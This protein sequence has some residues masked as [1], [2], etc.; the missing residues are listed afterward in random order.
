MAFW[1]AI[2]AVGA[3]EGGGATVIG[4]FVLGGFVVSFVCHAAWA[5]LLSAAPIRTA[6]IASRR[7]IE[8]ALGGFFTF[9]AFKLATSES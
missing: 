7:W 6:Y 5:V 3:T 8:L 2:A 1:L 9:A 4:A